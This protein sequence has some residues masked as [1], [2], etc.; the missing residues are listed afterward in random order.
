MTRFVFGLSAIVALAA[1]ASSRAEEVR[2][3]D[4][5]V[6]PFLQKHCVECHDAETQK[7][8]FRVDNLSPK[9]GTEN[10]PQWLEVMERINTGE[11]PP[12][13]VKVRPGADESARWWSGSLP[14]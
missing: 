3:I 4:K 10:T 2:D 7:G 11:M 14:G 13:K 1:T 6:Q 9:V 12:K 5:V 8:E